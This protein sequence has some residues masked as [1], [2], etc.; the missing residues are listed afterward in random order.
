MERI[1]KR[2]EQIESQKSLEYLEK[3]YCRAATKGNYTSG[4]K[5]FLSV[6]Y[7]NGGLNYADRYL[8][9]LRAGKRNIEEDLNNFLIKLK[10]KPSTSISMYLR[11][12]AHALL[13][14]ECFIRLTLD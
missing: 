4:M 5:M 14:R 10:G 6:T 7:E 13:I 12:R 9:E 1:V 2:K 3:D 11:A 8:G